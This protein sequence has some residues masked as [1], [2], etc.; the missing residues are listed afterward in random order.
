MKKGFF[1]IFLLSAF[2]NFGF[3]Q[4]ISVEENFLKSE[5]DSA[6]IEDSAEP[7][8]SSAE[9]KLKSAKESAR[10]TLGGM[11]NKTSLTFS[12]DTFNKDKDDHVKY[13]GSYALVESELKDKYV[14]LGAKL[15]YRLSTAE[16]TDEEKQN[17]EIKRAYAKLR[18]F[19]NNIMELAIGKLYSYYLPGGFFSLTETY[20][21]SS[22]W[23][24]TGVGAKTEFLGFTLGAALPVTETKTTFKSDWG[25][26]GSLMYNFASLSKE[27]PLT[28]GA[29]VLYWATG[30]GDED[31]SKVSKDDFSECYALNFSKRNFGFFK[32]FSVFA[33]YSRNTEP[34]VANS[35]LTPLDIVVSSKASKSEKALYE[36]SYN[37]VKKSN[38]FS[39]A[40]RPTIGKVK[41]T[42]ESE[43]GHSVKGNM[44]PFYSAF[45]VYFPVYG[46]VAL[47]PMAGYYAA[48]NTIDSSKSFD[49]WEI[50]PRLLLEFEKTT[51]TFG[52]DM[53]YTQLKD[54]KHYWTWEVPVRVKFKIGDGKNSKTED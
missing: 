37:D 43:V 10:K 8:E 40:F 36:A 31:V 32:N 34:Y 3:S 47:K 13:D 18:P 20:T 24:K 6:E 26:N 29:N 22:R 7:S 53:F 54:R 42:S 39:F 50:Y 17:I 15:Y 41:I 21:G 52:W 2:L 23:G 38:L 46:V 16:N 48:W 30:D 12:V 9:K 44:V 5:S 4:E 33:A 25:V 45:Q 19:G 51:L 1:S 27:V 49:S 28:L 35:M 11:S 14:T